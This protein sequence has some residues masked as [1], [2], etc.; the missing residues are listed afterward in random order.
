MGPNWPDGIKPP[1]SV[2]QAQREAQAAYARAQEQAAAAQRQKAAEDAHKA[3]VDQLGKLKQAG[4]PTALNQAVSAEMAAL[5]TQAHNTPYNSADAKQFAEALA[6]L[7]SAHDKGSADTLFASAC[8]D[9]AI[10]RAN[11]AV[12]GPKQDYAAAMRSL[13]GDLD[14]NHATPD[15]LNFTLGDTRTRDIANHARGSSADD[16][17]NIA[18]SITRPDANAPELL[19]MLVDQQPLETLTNQSVRSSDPA[20]KHDALLNDLM[21]ISQRLQGARKTSY[22]PSG[23]E[24]NDRLAQSLAHR[25]END[26]LVD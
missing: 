19:A 2:L 25:L 17:K 5:Y 14:V 9:A 12:N 18:Q 1:D 13:A 11:K 16:L 21:F 26:P 23:E 22:S 24:L 3:T 4:N 20:A 10:D 8:A 15:V 7:Q 6:L